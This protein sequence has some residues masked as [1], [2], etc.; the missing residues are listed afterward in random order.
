[1]KISLFSKQNNKKNT[2]HRRHSFFPFEN[3]LPKKIKNME[4]YRKFTH[5]H[6][7]AKH[8][9]CKFYPP[10][11]KQNKTLT[12]TVNLKRARAERNSYIKLVNIKSKEK[13]REENKN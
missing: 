13:N 2:R 4:K 11:N 9:S 12:K 7:H 3:L 6:S 5:T 8:P 1:M 10:V